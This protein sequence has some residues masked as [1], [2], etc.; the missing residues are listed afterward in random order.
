MSAMSEGD[1]LRVI[2]ST[3]SESLRLHHTQQQRDLAPRD[4]GLGGVVRRLD[5]DELGDAS[6]GVDA[7][8]SEARLRSKSLNTLFDGR[9]VH[10]S[11]SGEEVHRNPSPGSRRKLVAPRRGIEPRSQG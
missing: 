9:R 1:I 2:S 8:L 7:D 6:A 5:M 4:G 11:N 10:G 3:I